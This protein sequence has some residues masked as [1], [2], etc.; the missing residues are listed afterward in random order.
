MQNKVEYSFTIDAFEDE[1]KLDKTLI[2]NNQSF[3]NDL[4]QEI[5]KE[6]TKMDVDKE[7]KTN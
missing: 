4:N 3:C 1:I 2:A 6:E 5:N 7:T